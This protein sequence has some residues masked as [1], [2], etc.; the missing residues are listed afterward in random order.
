MMNTVVTS[1]CAITLLVGV[2]RAS[3]VDFEPLTGQYDPYQSFWLL[4][5]Y[6]VTNERAKVKTESR[7]STEQEAAAGADKPRR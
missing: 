6:H 5:R 4:T 3:W 7:A 1:L 2:A